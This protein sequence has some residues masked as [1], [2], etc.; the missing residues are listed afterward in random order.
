[1]SLLQRRGGLLQDL[2]K[3]N[4]DLKR[5]LSSVTDQ[6]Q[7]IVANS[8]RAL[9]VK[10]RKELEELRGMKQ[11]IAMV[12]EVTPSTDSAVAQKL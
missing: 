5:K 3:E 4:A 9:N 11:R 7:D 6:V 8:A 1:V 10:E 12:I 2:Q